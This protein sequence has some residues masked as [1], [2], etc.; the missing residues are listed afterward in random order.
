MMQ[1]ANLRNR[2][3]PATVRWL[4]IACNRRV[5]IQRQVRP[6]AIGKAYAYSRHLTPRL[7]YGRIAL[8]ARAV[9]EQRATARPRSRVRA[10]ADR[11]KAIRT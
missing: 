10:M 6:R 3:H 8:K 11:I 7:T 4:N 1:P 5:S 2:D 9:L